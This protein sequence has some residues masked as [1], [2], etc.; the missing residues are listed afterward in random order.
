[1]AGCE[2]HQEN[3]KKTMT[4]RKRKR[5]EDKKGDRKANMEA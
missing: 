4:P 3:Q 1:M 2:S 5:K